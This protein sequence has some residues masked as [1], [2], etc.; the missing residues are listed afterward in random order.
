MVPA[1]LLLSVGAALG[2]LALLPSRGPATVVVTAAAAST[3]LV[4]A[5]PQKQ[6]LAA[7]NR[8][9]DLLDRPAPP[10]LRAPVRASR[11]RRVAAPP[12]A[13]EYVRPAVGRLT[14]G[15]KWR[16]GRMHMGIDLAGPYGSPIRSVG[17]GQVL[18]AGYE[19]A[20][21]YIVRVQLEDG[22]VTFY[23]HNSTLTVTA[24]E[25][26][27]AGQ[28]IAREGNSG[29]STGPHVHFEVRVDGTP[30]NP[31]AWLASRGVYI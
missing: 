19:G 3:P 12:P 22:T 25:R 20:Y 7:N 2:G 17:A 11:A 14:S 13:P 5:E 29:R 21:G 24:G 1:V 31:I 15:F 28:I 27:S 16:W 9:L 10:V 8:S 6:A 4:L 26:V 30:I 23:A 18:T